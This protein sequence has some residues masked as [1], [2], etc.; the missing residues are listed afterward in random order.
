MFLTKCY[1]Y[2]NEI[3]R[4]DFIDPPNTC[5]NVVNTYTEY[6]EQRYLGDK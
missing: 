4:N 5:N 3:N 1:S 2:R 6:P